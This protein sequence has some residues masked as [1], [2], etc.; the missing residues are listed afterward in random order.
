[1]TFL[2]VCATVLTG[3]DRHQYYEMGAVGATLGSPAIE[4]GGGLNA[5][6]TWWANPCL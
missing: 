2:L 3:L 1:M 6:I 5:G 4:K